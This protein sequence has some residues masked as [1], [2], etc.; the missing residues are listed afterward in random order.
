M[1]H[2]QIE[3][4]GGG[5]PLSATATA[6]AVPSLPLIDRSNPETDTDADVAI[7]RKELKKNK[8]NYKRQKKRENKTNFTNRTGGGG[9]QSENI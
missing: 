6:E 8:K 3:E 5:G 7:L 1:I 9:E 4:G 2:H